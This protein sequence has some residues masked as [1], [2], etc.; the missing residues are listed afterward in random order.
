MSFVKKWIGCIVSAVA[1]IC[2]LALS[3]CSGMVVSA[4]IDSTA[5]GG[6]KTTLVDSTTKG[7]KVLTDSKLYEQAKGFGVKTEFLWMK[8]FAI[9]TLVVSILL[10]L[11]A[12]V[13]LLKNLNVIKYDSKI[14][15]IVGLVLVALLL[16]STIGLLV[17][18]NVY[19]GAMEDSILTLAKGLTLSQ[20]GGNAALLALVKFD[21][22]ASVG[23]YQPIML[24]IAI[25]SALAV[26]AFAFINRKQA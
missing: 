12:I 26:S 2:G 20:L 21:V 17:S 10:I 7:F 18:S 14:F 25:V 15:G 3:A 11:Y 22:S 24:A 5:I 13:M 23:L 9:I 6:K 4:I 8:A 1:G 19:A 16:I